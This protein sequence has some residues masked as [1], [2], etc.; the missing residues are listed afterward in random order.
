[1]K[2][3]FGGLDEGF[4]ILCFYCM[5]S[6]VDI[7]IIGFIQFRDF[8]GFQNNVEYIFYFF[9]VKFLILLVFG[10]NYFEKNSNNYS[11]FY[12]VVVCIFDC[13]YNNNNGKCL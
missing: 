5:F 7:V 2:Y 3:M 6:M 4:Q 8:L 11:Q 12:G 1:M 13:V 10:K 9:V